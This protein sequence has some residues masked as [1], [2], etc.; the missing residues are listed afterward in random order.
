MTASTPDGLPAA[1][2]KLAEVDERESEHHRETR[3]ALAAQQATLDQMA[4]QLASLLP[5]EPGPGYQPIP[6]VTWWTLTTEQRR[7]PI[8]RI[9]D[10]VTSIYKPLYGHLAASLGDCWPAHPLA[11]VTLDWLS[12]TWSVLYL[13]P[14]RSARDLT[15]QAEFST[16]ILPA[17]AAQLGAETAR[18]TQHTQREPGRWS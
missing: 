4:G 17:A 13:K 10:W 12:E 8:S 2:L 7:E 16:R 14:T 9:H 15:A 5:P 1:L 11:L 3:A 6:T 18:C